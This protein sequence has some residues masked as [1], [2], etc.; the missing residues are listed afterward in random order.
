LSEWKGDGVRM[1]LEE[2]RG[3]KWKQKWK[4]KWK[5]K[6]K[7][8]LRKCL[9]GRKREEERIEE[10]SLEQLE[11]LITKEMG[12]ALRRESKRPL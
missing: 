7:R 12:K 1:N 4:Q 6:W 2:T 11:Q 10:G 8:K 3:K 5:K 9:V